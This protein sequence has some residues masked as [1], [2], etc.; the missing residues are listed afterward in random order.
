MGIYAKYLFPYLMEAGLNRPFVTNERKE[1]LAA[2]R[3]RVL[4]IGF[5]TGLNL[6]C[7][8]EPVR[9]ITTIDANEGMHRLA[10][11]RVVASGKKV[12]HQVLDAA[13]LPFPDE[14]FDSVV[15]TFTLCSIANVEQALGEVRRV[16]APGGRFYFLEHGKSPEPQIE[17]WQNRITP[18][19]R[20][21]ADGCHMNRNIFAIVTAPGFKL[22]ERTEHYLAGVPKIYG[23]LY[24][25][26]AEK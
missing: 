19:N 24:R 2:V 20:I 25:G 14:S 7:Y 22:I 5:G 3:G 9:E 10:R 23:Y 8:P 17:K 26:V 13:R 21:I 1:A 11:A 16:L 18:I 6:A 12:V 15:S 4:E